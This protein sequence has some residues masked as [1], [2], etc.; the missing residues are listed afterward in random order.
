MLLWVLTVEDMAR[1]LTNLGLND[2]ALYE[3]STLNFTNSS[4][5]AKYMFSKSSLPPPAI[6]KALSAQRVAKLGYVG[7]ALHYTHQGWKFGLMGGYLNAA[8][9]AY[10]VA[11]AQ[12][13]EVVPSL[14][15]GT[16]SIG[17]FAATQAIIT[18]G[19][20][21][22][23][24]INVG[25]VTVLAMGLSMG[26]S[27]E[28]DDKIMQTTKF[29][30]GASQHIKRLEMGGNYQDTES[31]QTNRARALSEM[32]GSMQPAR[33]YLGREAELLHR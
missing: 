27:M 33:R 29:L 26:A 30:I 15:T 28:I 19:L 11:T 3:G 21:L 20:M 24:G 5:Y 10:Q 22:I 23:P 1:S 13:G 7:R 6:Q 31:A 9:V 17:T 12:K 32:S 18:G 25:V 14:I 8:G 16:I 2:K 4:T